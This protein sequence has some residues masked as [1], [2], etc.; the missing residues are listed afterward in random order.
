MGDDEEEEDP[1]IQPLPPGS[2]TCLIDCARRALEFC[3]K[4]LPPGVDLAKCVALRSLLC[5]GECLGGR[6][7]ANPSVRGAA[8]RVLEH[9]LLRAE[10]GYAGEPKP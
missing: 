6:D 7:A 3:Q 8:L 1:P 9:E 10:P 5:L 2:I 4:Y